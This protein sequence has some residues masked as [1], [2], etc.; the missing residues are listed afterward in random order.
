[1]AQDARHRGIAASVAARIASGEWAVGERL[2][3]RAA[4]ADEYGVHEQTVRLAV[5]ILRR[6]GLIEGE[7]RRRLTVAYAPAV[8]ALTDPDAPWPYG[9]DTSL[10]T[11]RATVELATRLDV[12][13]GAVLQRE[14]QEC[15]DPA[16]RSAMLVT[17]WWHGTRHRHAAWTVEVS[18][19]HVG[20]EEGHALG[21]LVDDVA[22]RLTRTRLDES[23]RPVETADVILPLDRWTLRMTGTRGLSNS[24]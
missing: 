2:P 11:C 6:Q 21:L 12:T 9:C 7:A 3:S 15:W 14:R 23:G 1:M 4:L 8:R 22:Y 5:R 13:A 10:G 16:G 24:R 17:S 19:V 20:E 18:T